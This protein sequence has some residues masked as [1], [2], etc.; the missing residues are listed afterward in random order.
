MTKEN[1]RCRVEH[2][3]SEYFDGYVLVARVAGQSKFVILHHPSPGVVDSA[4]TNAG[5]VACLYD[6]ADN[7]AGPLPRRN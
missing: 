2:E 7:I 6:V 1:I 5:I 4:A 3:L